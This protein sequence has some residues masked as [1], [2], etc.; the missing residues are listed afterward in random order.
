VGA[1]VGAVIDGRINVTD[2]VS[3]RSNGRTDR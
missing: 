2:Y 1:V 3:G